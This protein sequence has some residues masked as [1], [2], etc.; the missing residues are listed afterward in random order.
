[1]RIVMAPFLW[2]GRVLLWI[3][4]LPIGIWRSLRHHRKKGERRME[5]RMEEM[6]AERDR[7]SKSG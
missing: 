2:F 4:F 6:L 3:I 5:K 7:T 1:M